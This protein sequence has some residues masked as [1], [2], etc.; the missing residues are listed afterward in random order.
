MTNPIRQKEAELRRLLSEIGS[1]LVAFSGG[2]DSTFLAAVAHDVLDGRAVAV[3]AVSPAVPSSE[4]E[5][6]RELARAIGIRHETI[7]TSEMESPAYV[8]NAPDR[9]YHCKRDLFSRLRAMAQEMG[10][11]C[12]LDGSNVDDEGDFRPGRRAAFE[13]GVRAPLLEAGLSKEEIRAL[14]RERGLA[15]WDKL[16]MACLASRIPYGTP[17]S[18]EALRQI[19]AAEGILRGLGLRQ[20]RVRHHGKTARIEVSPAEMALLVKEDKRQL[21]VDGLKSLG[22]VY[23]TLDLAGFRS[24]S[25]NEG[26]D[27]P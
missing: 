2:V 8:Q 9:C 17:I 7:E 24:G 11:A 22:Y 1:A 10:L 20:L 23:V 3:T 26:L 4:V 16:S 21:I 15:T 18:L 27:S 13:Y 14:S 25:L 12:V 5:E 6:A 19:E